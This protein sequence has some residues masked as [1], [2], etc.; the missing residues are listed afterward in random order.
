[1]SECHRTKSLLKG[2]MIVFKTKGPQIR[3]I[4]HGSFGLS[5]CKSSSKKNMLVDKISRKTYINSKKKGPQIRCIPHRRWGLAQCKST[6]EEHASSEISFENKTFH[7][8]IKYRLKFDSERK[9]TRKTLV[10]IREANTLPHCKWS[11][12][13]QAGF[14]KKLEHKTLFLDQLRL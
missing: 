2:I 13:E 10:L 9:R 6:C 4:P 1:M 11:C 14:D 8:L 7:A 3:C 12:K 5:Q